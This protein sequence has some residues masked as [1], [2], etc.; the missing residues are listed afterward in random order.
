M[1]AIDIGNTSVNFAWFKKER[2]VKTFKIS[3]IRLT[4]K[5]V[6]KVLSGCGTEKILVCSVVPKITDIFDKLKLNIFIVGRDIEVPI[7]CSYNKKQVGVDRLIAAY[8]AKKL[9][10]DTRLIFDFGTA[11]TLDFLSK[12][13]AYEGGII[14]P[15]IGSTLR[16]LSQCALLPGEVKFKKTKVLIPKNTTDSINKGLEEGFSSMVN[17]LIKKYKQKLKVHL[18][19]KVVITGGD[20]LPLMHKLDFAY[21]Y[22]PLLVLRGLDFLAAQHFSA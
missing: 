3:S 8:T 20:V 16:S 21:R 4:A 2:V 11:I 5:A 19:N 12:T 15:G 18:K 7:R 17:S 13:G 22:E 14:L 9:F 6:R 10:S 1:I